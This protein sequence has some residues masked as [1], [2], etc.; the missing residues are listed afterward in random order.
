MLLSGTDG[1]SL[2]LNITG[3]Q[4]PNADDLQTRYSWH[5]VEG[6]ASSGDSSWPFRFAALTCDES[7]LLANWLKDT[8]GGLEVPSV[9]EFVEPNLKFEIVG[10]LDDQVILVVHLS[11]EFGA[12]DP[13]ALRL[14]LKLEALGTAADQWQA[15]VD[16]F[17]GL[18]DRQS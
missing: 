7:A 14:Q 2:T 9:L 17:P 15:D 18:L 8:S 5:V 16:R 13:T 1:D 12:P 3:Y 11:Q 10:R 6:R 4:F